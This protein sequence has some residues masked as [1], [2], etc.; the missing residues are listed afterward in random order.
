MEDNVKEEFETYGISD[1]EQIINEQRDRYSE[2]RISKLQRKCL[3]AK[4]KTQ[5]LAL[6]RQRLC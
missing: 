5:Q 4:G 3:P 1:L 6:V 2:E